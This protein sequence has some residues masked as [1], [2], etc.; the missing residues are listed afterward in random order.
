MPITDRAVEPLRWLTNA[1]LAA[2]QQAAE[3][4]TAAPLVTANAE[5]E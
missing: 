3:T 5:K 4:R 1:E 2:Q